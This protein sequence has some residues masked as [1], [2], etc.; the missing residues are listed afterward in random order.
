MSRRLFSVECG[1][2]F[3]S[4]LQHLEACI[5]AFIDRHGRTKF[6]DLPNMARSLVKR[7]A[8]ARCLPPVALQGMILTP[9]CALLLASPLSARFRYRLPTR[10]IHAH[11]PPGAFLGWRLRTCCF[12]RYSA[13]RA[14]T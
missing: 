7:L 3:E 10:P 8:M 9:K 1:F 2:D 12:C 4:G 6:T 13:R 14:N 11:T 5:A